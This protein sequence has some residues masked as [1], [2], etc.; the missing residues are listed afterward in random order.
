MIES[1]VKLAL[2][3]QKY[4]SL[5]DTKTT[6][7]QQPHPH[8]GRPGRIFVR[9]INSQRIMAIF[10]YCALLARNMTVPNGQINLSVT[11]RNEPQLHVRNS[12]L[13][14]NEDER[15][16]FYVQSYPSAPILGFAMNPKGRFFLQ[17][18]RSSINLFFVTLFTDILVS[19][20]DTIPHSKMLNYFTMHY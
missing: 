20:R 5:M 17:A 10:P 4:S 11:G 16:F 6:M 2:Y 7:A 12:N 9:K 15:P 18:L 8:L 1:L 19:V 14:T 3:A 13:L